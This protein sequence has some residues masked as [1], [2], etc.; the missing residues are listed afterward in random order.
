MFMTTDLNS[1]KYIYLIND[2]HI[3]WIHQ[4]TKANALTA[5]GEFKKSQENTEQLLTS[6]QLPFIKAQFHIHNPSTSSL[7]IDKSHGYDAVTDIYFTLVANFCEMLR[8]TNKLQKAS[9]LLKRFVN[10]F[11]CSVDFCYVM[12]RVYPLHMAKIY[13]ILAKIKSQI[14]SNDTIHYIICGLA[15]LVHF[16]QSQKGSYGP[17]C[18]VDRFI[19]ADSLCARLLL[20][21]SEQIKE[22]NITVNLFLS[23][24]LLYCKEIYHNDEQN[25]EALACIKKLFENYQTYHKQ[26]I[27]TYLNPWSDQFY[28]RNARAILEA[29]ILVASVHMTIFTSCAVNNVIQKRTISEDAKAIFKSAH[30]LC[31]LY[32]DIIGS[33]QVIYHEALYAF[34]G[35]KSSKALG[36]LDGVQCVDQAIRCLDYELA[37]R[38]QILTHNIYHQ[39]ANQCD[40]KNYYEMK[41]IYTHVALKTAQ[42]ADDY[43]TYAN[44]NYYRGIVHL[45]MG[46]LCLDFL[47]THQE[48]DK[49]AITSVI[50]Q[51]SP[52]DLRIQTVIWLFEAFN[53]FKNVDLN[54]SLDVYR[55]QH[56]TCRIYLQMSLKYRN[57]FSQDDHCRLLY[58]S[59]QH[60]CTYSEH[61]K[62]IDKLLKL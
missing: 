28:Q 48:M 25:C 45:C 6:Y 27:I 32:S 40:S 9:E 2:K 53:F 22:Q 42:Q 38:I 31:N 5:F 24:F 62:R 13:M 46:K 54:P 51:R 39:I 33:I 34:T 29:E 47:D 18:G 49:S 57:S 36:I 1:Q 50:D 12:T 35:E 14:K 58:Y 3:R 61:L 10:Q 20:L 7:L 19:V 37:G 16:Y 60:E 17:K 8:K 41:N 15:V 11:S 56:E 30:M 59:D 55:A 21:T 23:K 26:I 4:S 43:F 44:N 52:I